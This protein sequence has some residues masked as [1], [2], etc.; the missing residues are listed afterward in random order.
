MLKGMQTDRK[1]LL[2]SAAAFLL[3]AASG[4]ASGDPVLALNLTFI[5][6]LIMTIPYSLYRFF[7]FKRI[8]AYEKEFPNFLR[9]LAES[10][11]AGLTIIQA[12]K[13][14]A[15]SD[16]GPLTLEIRKVNNQI[17]WN[18][19]LEKVL[20]DWSKRMKKSRI[21]VRSIMII[22]EANKSGGSIESTME[23]LAGNIETIKEVQEEKSS[24]LNQQ[25]IMMYAIFF[26]FLGITIALLKFLIPLLQ[27]QGSQSIA[28]IFQ[29][30]NPNPCAPCFSSAAPE[31]FGCGLFMGVSA[32]LNFG[33][34][35]AA[36]S[37]YRS[38]FLVM[39]MIQG[40]FSGLIAG[41]IVSDSVSAGIKHSLIMTL[42][43]F[44]IFILLIK[45][46]FA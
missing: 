41:Q 20:N 25:V 10:Q 27:P 35:Q 11:R 36:E 32:S 22:Q 3:L 28:G 15:K 39:I 21:I 43:G 6:A 14:A 29:D 45:A 5:G 17:S 26:I 16:Y 38:L 12:V 9:D 23:S 33:A 4:I 1:I 13:S 46:G 40:F 18:V 42:S 44:F 2:V 19:P 37:Y 30:F 8:R 31:C 34:P 7:E 24:L